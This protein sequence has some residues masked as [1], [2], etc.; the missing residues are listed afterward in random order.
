MRGKMILVSAPPLWPKIPP[1]NLLMPAGYL[2]ERGYEVQALDLN[3]C[4]YRAAAPA[5]QAEWLKSRNSQWESIWAERARQGDDPQ[6]GAA[7]AELAGA[8][9]VGFSCFRSNLPVS[10][11]VAE[12]LRRLSPRTRIVFG[13]PEIARQYFAAGEKIPPSLR[14]AA[15]ELVVGEGELALEALAQGEPCRPLVLF[16]ELPDLNVCS[17]AAGYDLV[18]R[19]DYPRADTVAVLA[20]RGCRRG[21]RFCVE[22]RLYRRL[23]CRS[24]ENAAAEIALH[25]AQGVRSF[26]MHDSMFNADLQFLERFCELVQERFGG[27]AWEAQMAV[28]PRM[29]RTL[30]EKI[31][32]SGCYHLFIGLES[33]CDRTLQRMGKG[34][35]AAQAGV[36]FE[37]V[38]AAGLSFGVS[39]LVGFPG[40]T[41]AD[42]Q[43][44]LDFLCARRQFISRIEQ[45]NPYVYYEGS[46]A[47][48]ADYQRRPEI[49]ERTRQCV[50]VLRQHG[51]RMN[52]AFINNLIEKI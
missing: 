7:L 47:D 37:Q 26:I 51:F 15:D 8:A 17:W 45:I 49:L 29:S 4:C 52:R 36:F 13:G 48:A 43:E 14:A 28:E 35:S 10:L 20:G 23:R 12:Q 25:R 33:G 42:V 18:R 6:I 38:A 40:E 1:L 34:F 32:R 24:A 5:Q 11:V 2:R 46:D 50:D 27:I 31:K 41:D 30:L 22:R 44:S 21:C 39:L 3:N 9:V 19:A 16:E